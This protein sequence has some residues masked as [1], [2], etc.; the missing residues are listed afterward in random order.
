MINGKP[1]WYPHHISE[2]VKRCTELRKAIERQNAELSV[3]QREEYKRAKEKLSRL[4]Q[5][6]DSLE[7]ERI[8]GKYL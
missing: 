8:S 4:E 6:R 7:E 2:E 1:T 3:D 5:E